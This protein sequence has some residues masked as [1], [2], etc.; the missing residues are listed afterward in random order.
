MENGWVESWC[1]GVILGDM[2]WS[3]YLAV[4]NCGCQDR[5]SKT[6]YNMEWSKKIVIK[7]GYCGE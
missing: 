6:S 7:A 5:E 1:S 3:I 4:R 2:W